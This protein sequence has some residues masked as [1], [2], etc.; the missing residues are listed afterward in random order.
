ML[1]RMCKEC[2]KRDAP[3][4]LEEPAKKIRAADG[5]VFVT[6]EHSSLG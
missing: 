5:F 3:A 4:V 1:D 2:P 6:A